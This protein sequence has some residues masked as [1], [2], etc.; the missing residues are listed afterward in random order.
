MNIKEDIKYYLDNRNKI[1][2]LPKHNN[3]YINNSN[4]VFDVII[5]K[6]SINFFNETCAYF[7]A[8]AIELTILSIV[9]TNINFISLDLFEI[10]NKKRFNLPDY[11]IDV[12]YDYIDSCESIVESIT[13]QCIDFEEL[14]SKI[15]IK[16]FIIDL[17]SIAESLTIKNKVYELEYYGYKL[18]DIALPSE[19]HL[20]A[21]RLFLNDLNQRKPDVVVNQVFE[22]HTS[23]VSFI[24]TENNVKKFVY[25]KYAIF[26]NDAEFDS[27][28]TDIFA[29]QAIKEN[30]VPYVVAIQL[31]QAD[32][33]QQ[34]HGIILKSKGKY[35]FKATEFLALEKVEQ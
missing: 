32:E 2:Q 18:T 30:A 6:K 24:C 10:E 27:R 4:K 29:R 13:N 33:F 16:K 25:V 11:I 9:R 35:S 15:D 3:N 19:T 20:F 17:Q 34:E 31:K 28:I 1:N 8:K 5:E 22:S 23:I 14:T 21:L 7:F 26:P 12:L